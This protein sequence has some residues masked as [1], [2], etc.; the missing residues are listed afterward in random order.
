MAGGV[1]S[2]ASNVAIASVLTGIEEYIYYSC[3]PCSG[4]QVHPVAIVAVIL[5]IFVA[6][7]T[8]MRWI[9]TAIRK[10]LQRR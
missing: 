2:H 5:M 3:E 8:G 4:N 9:A 7:V 6:V 10:Q 1:V